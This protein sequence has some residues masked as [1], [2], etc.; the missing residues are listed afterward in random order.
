MWD[1]L[2]SEEQLK[3]MIDLC[4]ASSSYP[5]I[6]HELVY[7]CEGVLNNK[8]RMLYVDH[9]SGTIADLT[10]RRIDPDH[11]DA[12]NQYYFNMMHAPIELRAKMLWCAAT[13]NEP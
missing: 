10:Y 2:S 6:D 13:G 4:G 3:F 8:Q 9:M 7:L 5:I 12:A 1:E 11:P